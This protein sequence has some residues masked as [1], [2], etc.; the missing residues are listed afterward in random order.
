MGNIYVLVKTLFDEMGVDYVIPP[1]CS[2]RTLEI[3]TKHSPEMACLPLKINIGNFIESI[4][5]GADTII[6]TGAC[7]PCRFG[8]YAEMHREI[9]KD[10]GYDVEIIALEYNEKGLFDLLAKIKKM[11]NNRR[12]T[13]LVV[14]LYRSIKALKTIDRLEALSFR[15]R[16][17]EQEKGATDK[18]MNSIHD[19]MLVTKGYKQIMEL[20]LGAEQR[21]ENIPLI[22]NE[23]IIKIGIVGEIY[24]LIEPFTNVNIEKVLGNMGIEVHRS[25][26][27]SQWIIDHII[28]GPL[29]IGGVEDFVLAAQPYLKT[30]IGGH[31][32]ETI[33]HSVLYAK[34]G[35]DGVIQIYPLTCMPEIVADSIMPSV[36]HD[37]EL[38]TLTLIMDEITGEAGY[39]TRIDAFADMLKRR[40]QLKGV[41]NAVML[42]RC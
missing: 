28:K 9:L 38:P 15:V 31:A 25:L 16:P 37:Y 22:E 7:G 5:K 26:Y 20:L 21:L 3:G 34:G 13:S 24:T 6:I 30:K 36:S 42:S 17:R 32:I 2:K 40:K 35:Y 41:A 14:P 11:I 8:Y 12:L 1:K 19:K 10:L 18:I 33:G 27:I 23:D 29:N 4:E 39:I